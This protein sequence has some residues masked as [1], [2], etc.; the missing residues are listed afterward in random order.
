MQRVPETGAGTLHALIEAAAARVPDAV[1]VSA[2]D[3]SVGYARLVA[4]AQRLGRDLVRAGARPDTFVGVAV[5]RSAQAVVALLGVLFA[6][7]AYV[8]I[9]TD[10]PAERVRQIASDARLRLVTGVDASVAEAAGAVFVP[11][12]GPSGAAGAEAF[13]PPRIHP[14]QA[15]YAIFTSG[16]TGRPK[17]V[18]ISHR[19]VVGSTTARF[20][21]YPEPSAY[22]V[23]APL[24]IDAAA[25]GL[26]HTLALGGRVVLPGEEE[27]RDPQLLA[28]LLTAQRIS[29]LDGLPSQYAALLG[30]HPAAAAG[31][32]CVILGGE[33]L[34]HPLLRQHLAEVPQVELHN[35][36]GPTE[37]TVWATTHRCTGADTGPR[38]PIGTAVAGLRAEVLTDGLEPAAPGETGEIWLS[39]PGLARG[40]LARAALTAERFTACPDPRRPG[41]R[42]YRTGDLGHIDRAG[43]LVYHGRSDHLV[44]VRGHRVELGEIEARLLAHPEVLDA[45]VVPHS[46]LTGVRLVAV[47][48]LAPAAAAG[49]GELSAF[50]ARRLPAYMLPALWRRVDALPLTAG[51]KVDR[52]RL[53]A[54]ATTVGSALRA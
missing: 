5:D 51:G 17:G 26:Y 53:Q 28:D 39:G 13:Q 16:S 8:P 9:A 19:S 44:K 11:V 22:A 21:V 27:I 12:D 18:V 45:V 37:S 31:L 48:V 35:E 41:E 42:M 52:L 43:R 36:Y 40:Y 50:A 49:A 34:P 46:G 33:A 20:G 7:A 30:F 38:L 25:A 47:T 4:R 1:A 54:E 14:D 6:G 23:L 15:A 32:R 2:P 24:S 3:E 29:H 10:L